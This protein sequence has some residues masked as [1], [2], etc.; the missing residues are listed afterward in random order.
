MSKYKCKTC[1]GNLVL[2]IGSDTAFCD[3]CGQAEPVDPQ[4]M[5]K[6]QDI[7]QSAETLMRTNSLSGYTDALTRL[8]SISFIPQAKEKA[9]FCEQRI[10]QLRQTR[11]ERLLRKDRDDGKNA[12][13]GIIIVVLILLFLLATAVSVGFL[14]YHLIR[15]D[16]SPNAVIVT[17]SVAAALIVM[18]IIGKIAS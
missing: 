18:L 13:L 6:Y 4:D 1:G 16:L 9:D 5:K 11:M 17:A 14:V 3:H 12:A 8:Q 7:Y 15:G 10:R 2:T